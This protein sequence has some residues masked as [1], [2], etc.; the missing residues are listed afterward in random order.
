[1]QFGPGQR[2]VFIGDSITDSERLRD[3]PPYG[4]GYMSLVRAFVTAR[5]PELG[6]TWFNTGISG[7]TVRDLD[8]RWE[9]DVVELKPHWL[10]VMIGINDIWRAFEDRGS[11]AV[12]IGEYEETL[13]RLLKRAVDGT[14]CKL[15]LA[16]PYLIEADQAEPQ[17]VETR[18][19]CEVV[20]RLAAEFGALHVRSQE[21]FDRAL[22]TTSSL[23][24]AHDRIHPN[25]PGHAVLAQ[26]FLDVLE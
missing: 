3:V 6:L 5:H 20:A 9:E 7:N 12:P 14:G 25:L 22:T 24:W 16:D 2:I 19:Y 8:G 17:L 21:A 23:D 1:M 10:S 4:N 11:E 13:H 15:I 18:R 26:A